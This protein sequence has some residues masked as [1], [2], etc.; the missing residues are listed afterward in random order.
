MQEN[1]S[2]ADPTEGA[3]IAPQAPYLVGR[4]L[5]PSNSPLISAFQ[6]WASLLTPQFILHNSKHEEA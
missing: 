5:M 1:L 6:L 2:A 3:Y 4:G